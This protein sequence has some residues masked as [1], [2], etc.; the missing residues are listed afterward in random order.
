MKK[1]VEK[2]FYQSIAVGLLIIVILVSILGYLV[3]NVFNIEPGYFG[4][5]RQVLLSY[6]DSTLTLDEGIFIAKDMQAYYEEYYLSNKSS[7]NW[8]KSYNDGKTYE[9]VILD[10]TLLLLKEVFLFSE[11]AKANNYKLTSKD[12]DNIS[13]DAKAYLNDNPDFVIDA[14]GANMKLLEKF[15]TRTTYYGKVCDEIYNKADLTVETEDVR[16]CLV[17]IVTISP[18]DF[19]SPKETAEKIMERVNNGEVLAGVAEK[20]KA[21]VTKTNIGPNSLEGNELE[22]LC[23]SLKDGQCQMLTLK[24]SYYIVYCYQAND[25]DQTA[26]AKEQK[27]QELKDKAKLD[28]YNELLKTMT[29]DIDMDAWSFINFDNPIYTSDNIKESILT[30]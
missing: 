7:I 15:Y 17:A 24:G 26:A 9:D 23:L 18:D 5:D 6:D 4:T 21:K 12:L 20:Y 2:Y 29:L 30:K 19:D 16:Q 22:K 11:Y 3:T 28:F 8:D 14:T 25:Q 10:D 27:K 13:A 1:F